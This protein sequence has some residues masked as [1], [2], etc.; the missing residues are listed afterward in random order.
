MTFMKKLLTGKADESVHQQFVRFGKGIYKYRAMATIKKTATSIKIATT[1]EYST[2]LALLIAR[3]ADS[4]VKISGMFITSNDTT[5][6]LPFPATYTKRMGVGRITIP[7]VAIT[8]EKLHEFLTQNSTNL[9]L[10]NLTAANCS[11]TCKQTIPNPKKTPKTTDEGVE[12]TPK[13]GHCKATFTNPAV[14]DN[15][16]FETNDYKTAT[17]IHTYTITDFVV[18]AQYKNDPEQARIHAQRTG[19]IIRDLTLDGVTSK[20]EYPFTA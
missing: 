10:L 1:H 3:A 6:T 5:S 16:I 4:P 2:D 13:I 19:T 14:A 18:P 7:D 12:E 20:K 8:K 9:L 17:V 15:F 11:L